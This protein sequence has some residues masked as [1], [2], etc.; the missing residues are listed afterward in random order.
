MTFF[1]SFPLNILINS[2]STISYYNVGNICHFTW[3][4]A[5][6]IVTVSVV[7]GFVSALIPAL[8]AS[9]QNPVETLRSE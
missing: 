2:A 1:L 5:L 3:W 6:I 8:K 4:H 7:L 9:K